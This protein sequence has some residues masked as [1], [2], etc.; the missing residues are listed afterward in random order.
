MYMPNDRMEWPHCLLI[1]A[2]QTNPSQTHGQPGKK[3]NTNYILLSF[4]VHM[5]HPRNDTVNQ[6]PLKNTRTPHI[7]HND[8]FPWACPRSCNR[9]IRA[10]HRRKE[11]SP[12]LK[13]LLG[14]IAG[15]RVPVYCVIIRHHENLRNNNEKHDGE[16]VSQSVRQSV[17][18]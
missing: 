6:R 4:K 17:S 13:K 7:R 16:T 11:L 2:I 14:E 1:I 8:G 5:N 10:A 18:H 3:R 15:Q 12:F 9:L